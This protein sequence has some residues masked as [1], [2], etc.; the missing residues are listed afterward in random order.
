MKKIDIVIDGGH[1]GFDWGLN[2][3][4]EGKRV[5]HRGYHDISEED[6]NLEISNRIAF[7]FAQHSIGYVLTRWGDR[8]I[9]LRDRCRIANNSRAKL[10][11]SI[12]CNYALNSAIRG[13]ETF[14]YKGSKKGPVIAQKVQNSLTQLK[15]SHN[16]G[17]K[18]GLF[19]VLKHT[20]MPS[21]IVE[22]G[23]LSNKTDAEYLNNTNNQEVIAYNIFDAVRKHINGA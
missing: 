20:I 23:F 11:L 12:H 9:G 19:Y 13:I 1:G 6:I 18:E 3:Q 2:T 17:I 22:L 8:Y 14:H 5:P 10:F 21:I 7:Y 4:V 15:Y 16:R